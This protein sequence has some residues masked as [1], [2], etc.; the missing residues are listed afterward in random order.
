MTS[1]FF[2]VE[3]LQRNFMKHGE[4]YYFNIH[5]CQLIVMH[6]WRKA[7]KRAKRC[8]SSHC[9]SKYEHVTP[10]LQELHWLSVEYKI[11][12]KINLLTFKC[13]HDAAPSYLQE[14]LET[15]KPAR[16]LR[17]FSAPLMLKPVKYNMET[18]GLRSFSAH[19]PL[20]WNEVPANYFY[21]D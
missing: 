14:L 2:P 15:Y 9:E 1:S 11:I 18:Y 5:Q 20:L 16:S 12:F 17:S 10:V 19:V 8:C 4:A 7:T 13:L 21:Y 6:Y 3:D